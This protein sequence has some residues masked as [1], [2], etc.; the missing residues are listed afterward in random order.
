MGQLSTEPGTRVP[1]V[2]TFGRFQ[3]RVDYK[4]FAGETAGAISLSYF[5][6]KTGHHKLERAVSLVNIGSSTG[7]VAYGLSSPLNIF[8][9]F[10]VPLP[11]RSNAFMNL[12]ENGENNLWATISYGQNLECK[13][14]A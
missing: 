12:A 14:L 1:I 10:G 5:F 6:H 8:C 3:R 7:A 9:R 13:V 11:P 4:F 2:R